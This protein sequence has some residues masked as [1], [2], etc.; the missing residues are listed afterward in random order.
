MNA[1]RI[2]IARNQ[3]KTITRP[4]QTLYVKS[5]AGGYLASYVVTDDKNNIIFYKTVNL[6]TRELFDTGNTMGANNQIGV[7][8]LNEHYSNDYIAGDALEQMFTVACE[9]GM[10]KQGTLPNH[11]VFG[12]SVY[13]ADLEELHLQ[14]DSYISVR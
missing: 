14:N 7:E 3:L 10:Y 5:N 4:F 11:V 13:Y 1:D 9:H 6:L 8:A 2:D 12:Q